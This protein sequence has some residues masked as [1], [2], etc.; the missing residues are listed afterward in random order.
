MPLIRF[1]NDHDIALEGADPVEVSEN[2]AKVMTSLRRAV[3]VTDEPAEPANVE[4]SKPRK[5]RKSK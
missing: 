5:A 1:T 2:R 4:Q 3:L